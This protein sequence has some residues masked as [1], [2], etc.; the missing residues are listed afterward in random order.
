[1]RKLIITSTLFLVLTNVAVLSGIAYNRSDNPASGITLTERELTITEYYSDTNENSG[2]ALMLNWKSLN[3]D[4]ITG[5]YYYYRDRPQW[6]NDEKLEAIGFDLDDI[7]KNKI[8]KNKRKYNYDLLSSDVIFVVE[9]NDAA[10]RQDVATTE[11]KL[12]RLEDKAIKFPDDSELTKKL[13]LQREKLV[14]MKLSETRL[15]IIDAGHDKQELEKKYTDRNK[16]LLMRG[17]LKISWFDEK[18]VGSIRN[19]FIRRIHVPLPYSKQLSELTNG[20]MYHI[21]GGP[22]I[23]PRYQV[24]LKLGKRLEPWIESVSEKK[25]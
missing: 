15:Y 22:P 18:I 13:A 20:V 16:Y 23:A 25:S 8:R 5:K 3:D 24:M 4:S 17:E 7:I 14:R 19:L 9:Y 11:K 21:Y 10:Y 1:M 6:L 12:N 2:T